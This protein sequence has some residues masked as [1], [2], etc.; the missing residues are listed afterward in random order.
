MEQ[1]KV[2][3]YEGPYVNEDCI[4]LKYAREAWPSNNLA[5]ISAVIWA[6]EEGLKCVKVYEERN[7][8][9]ERTNEIIANITL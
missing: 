8:S 5:I 9:G 3:H 6:S 1:N 7:R 2:Y 4:S